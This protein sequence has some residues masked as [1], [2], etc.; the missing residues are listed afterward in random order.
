MQDI[1]YWIWLSKLNLN[2][3]SLKKYLEKY[4]PE[5]IWN[6]ERNVKDFFTKEEIRK[7]ENKIYKKDLQKHEAYI[8]K[9]GIKLIKITDNNYPEKL[10][11]IENPPIVLYALGNIS[12]LREK[13]I[14]IVGARNCTEY[15]KTVATAFA[16]LLSK[17]NIVITSGLA[18]GI[19]KSAHQGTIISKGKT[20]AVIGTGIDIIYPRENKELFKEI[21]EN[22]GLVI[23]EYPLETK[24]EKTN[25][26]RRNRI[27]S[28]ISDGVLV[29]EAGE[30]SGALITVDF[31]LEQGKSIYVVPREYFKLCF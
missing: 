14:A 5:N 7:I 19:D 10:R 2:P 16:Y 18:A 31:A 26:P 20:I 30:K 1:K 6:L 12:L 25:F 17:D 3:N 9:Y 27:I 28:G 4:T 8:K 24:P 13:N 29:V 23:S 15:G 22:N 21:I 11:N